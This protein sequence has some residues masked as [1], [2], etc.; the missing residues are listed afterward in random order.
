MWLEDYLFP[1]IIIVL[2]ISCGPAIWYF[3]NSVQNR[4]KREIR[5]QYVELI[6]EK[7]DVIKTAL[8]MGKS[9]DEIATGE[10]GGHRKNAQDTQD[11]QSWQGLG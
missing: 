8:A 1:L 2:G 6:K 4:E 11:R 5:A 7:L 3:M 10:A 9:D